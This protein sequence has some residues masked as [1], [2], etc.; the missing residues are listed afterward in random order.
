MNLKILLLSLL[1]LFS[2]LLISITFEIKQNGT[3]DFTSIQAGIEQA[4]DQDT[5]LVYAGIYYENIDFLGKKIIVS[6]LFIQEQDNSFIHNTII[7]GNQNGSCVK[8]SGG[9]DN[10]TILSGFTL[11]NGSGSA[12]EQVSG[13]VGGGIYCFDSTP[14]IQNCIITNNS[15]EFGGG[16]FSDATLST[17]YSSPLLKNCTIKYNH[18]YEAC[19]GIGSGFISKFDFDQNAPCNIYF[20]SAAWINDIGGS[21]KQ[22]YPTIAYIDTFTVLEPDN[23]FYKSRFGEDE[24]HI[25]NGK[26]E[27]IN[28]DLF[29]SPNGDD[30][31]SGLTTDAPLQRITTALI[32]IA[33]DSLHS[34]TIHLAPGTYSP[35]V[36][37]E[38]FPFNCRSYVSIIGENLENTIIDVEG[39]LKIFWGYDYEKNFSI[40]NLTF[41]N[42][43]EE[44]ASFIF[45]LA[46]PRG[47]I[48][49]NIEIRGYRRADSRNSI[50]TFTIGDNTFLDSTSL[51]LDNITIKDCIGAR[52]ISLYAIEECK[53]S[54]LL[55]SN[56]Q[57]DIIVENYGGGGIG[58]GGNSN[59]PDRY[60][61]KIINSELSK[62]EL[63]DDGFQVGGT[64]IIVA[65]NTNV[66][67][68]NCTIGDN[69]SDIFVS[70]ALYLGDNDIDCNLVNSIIYGNTPR[71]IL[72]REPYQDGLPP[73][74]LNIQNSL[75]EGGS[76]DILDLGNNNI[77]WL[78]GNLDENPEWSYDDSF[79]YS[80][81]S[82]SPCINTGTLA[83]PDGIELPEFDLAG[84]PRIYGNT[85]DMGAYEFQGEQ[86]IEYDIVEPW[87][88]NKIS[89][90]PNPFN[91]T[92]TIKLNLIEEGNIDLSIYNI[93]GQ[94]VK[95][96]ANSFYHKGIYNFIWSGINNNNKQVASGHYLIK[97][98]IDGNE[99]AVK[100]CILLK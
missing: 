71:S 58:I 11:Q 42:S 97:L 69:E 62:N 32:R 18:A 26:I 88:I 61:Y 49:E 24:L 39:K 73:I 9:E 68:I 4:T 27:P 46:Q 79:P 81:T 29:V 60:N 1:S 16:I 78:D 91:P 50:A 31:N 3:G 25:N 74:N 12:R 34:N 20:N 37:D 19:G 98:L 86:S 48:I 95:T 30:N 36:N 66:D 44:S 87:Q 54:N 65:S 5:I 10:T 94:K 92:T 96:M 47:V 56:N 21:T 13:F 72:L 35:S 22:F 89:N 59:F 23:T 7:D 93:K 83:L 45:A 8:F 41:L 85:I 55:I 63:I 38:R 70:A 17:G 64:A 15:A 99:K 67:I 84:Y 52:P 75:V 40:K 28:N 82:S 14:I 57:S 43:L 80:L 77:N 100:Q 51:L 76:D 6:S 90:Y 2:S 33:S 53:M